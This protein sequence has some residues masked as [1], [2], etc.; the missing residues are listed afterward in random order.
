MSGLFLPYVMPLMNS[1]RALAKTLNGET[2]AVKYP[3]MPVM[4]KTPSCSVVVAPP[5][6]G[7]KG[8][9]TI[10]KDAEGVHAQF[11][12]E[13][14]KLHGYALVGKAIEHKQTLTKEL[15]AILN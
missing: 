9:W 14:G 10:K 1:A 11:F 4:V 12:D 7:T 5:A 2:T 8:K 6:S 15:P 3:A 13:A